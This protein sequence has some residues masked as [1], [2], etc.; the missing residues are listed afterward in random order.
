MYQQTASQ[1]TGTNF[2]FSFNP[3]VNPCIRLQR[4]NTDRLSWDSSHDALQSRLPENRH[5]YVPPTYAGFFLCS[6]VRVC[7]LPVIVH[8]TFIADADAVAVMYS[9]VRPTSSSLHPVSTLLSLRT[10]K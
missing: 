6:G 4:Q 9:A 2:H 10:T 8:S 7:R 3:A 1:S 5:A